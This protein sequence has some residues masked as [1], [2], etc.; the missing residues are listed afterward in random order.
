MSSSFQ[1]GDRVWVRSGDEPWWPAKVLDEAEV[2][3]LVGQSVPHNKFG[4]MYY[5]VSDSGMQ[6]G[7]AELSEL[8]HFEDSSMRAVATDARLL[9]AI[10]AAKEDPKANPLKLA[11]TRRTERKAEEPAA[12]KQRKEERKQEDRQD[13]DEE[14]EVEMGSYPKSAKGFRHCDNSFLYDVAQRIQKAAA[15]KDL[16]GVRKQLMRLDRVNVSHEQLLQT[17][18]GVAVGDILGEPKLKGIFPLAKAIIGWWAY[19][20]PKATL[21]AILYVRDVEKDEI[22]EMEEAKDTIAAAVAVEKLPFK[23]RVKA[24]FAVESTFIASLGSNFDL[25][26]FVPELLKSISIQDAK[27]ELLN[28]ISKPDHTVLRQKLLSGAMTGPQF[29]NTKTEDLKTATETE[30][31]KQQ[32][33]AALKAIDEANEE[34]PT[35]LF[36]PCPKCG[37]KKATYREQQTRGADEPT[38][39]F[40]RCVECKTMWTCE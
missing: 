23:E 34:V 26:S 14:G 7:I 29:E 9:A 19:A 25:D 8:D 15:A 16:V 10:K 38:T 33:A 36:D 20:L 18:I 31:Q 2:E 39:K 4:V 22:V 37:C 40:V 13:A 6:V 28:Q 11:L 35:E 24:A 30:L 1:A 17:K 5:D 21:E 27:R 12:K 32:T 3:L